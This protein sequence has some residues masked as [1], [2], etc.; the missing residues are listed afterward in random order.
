MELTTT[1]IVRTCK[2]CRTRA[3][4][5]FWKGNAQCNNCGFEWKARLMRDEDRG[6]GRKQ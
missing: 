1:R 3:H 5:L 2:R 6:K 4:V